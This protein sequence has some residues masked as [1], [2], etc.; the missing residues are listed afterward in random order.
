MF[1]RLLA[2]VSLVAVFGCAHHRDVRPGADGI[3][4]VVVVGEDTDEASKSA[5][6]QSQHYCEEKKKEAVFVDEKKQYTGDMDE[7]TYKS[8]KRIGKV[9]QVIGGGVYTMGGK[10]ESAIGGIAGLGGTAAREAAGNGYTVEMR[11][12]CQ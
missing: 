7:E 8:T 12:K 9:A 4:R 10:N 2:L 5:I 1:K 3:H 6:K 11:F